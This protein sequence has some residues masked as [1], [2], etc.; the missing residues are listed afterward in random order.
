MGAE[1]TPAQA[2]ASKTYIESLDQIM[3]RA[4]KGS[5]ERWKAEAEKRGKSVNQ[6]IIDKVN[7]TA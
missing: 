1:Y 4:P 2:R 6:Y 5:R 3:I 7:G